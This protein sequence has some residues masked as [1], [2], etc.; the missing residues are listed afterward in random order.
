MHK[1]WAIKN[2]CCAKPPR[3]L[4]GD[5]L[6]ALAHQTLV[7]RSCT[8]IDSLRQVG[9]EYEVP[10]GDLWET[11]ADPETGRDLVN[12]GDEDYWNVTLFVG[13]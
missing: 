13:N 2:I 9:L 1:K 8:Y 11:H 12:G 6:L 5:A 4:N 7:D 10:V 3:A